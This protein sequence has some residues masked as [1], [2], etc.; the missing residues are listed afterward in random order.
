MEFSLQVVFFPALVPHTWQMSVQL[1]L[2]DM[3]AGKSIA[4]LL[5]YFC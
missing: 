1:I 2:V 5:F 3:Q 4:E